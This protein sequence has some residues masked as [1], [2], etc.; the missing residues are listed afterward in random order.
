MA[1][2]K[3][4]REDCRAS[5]WQGAGRIAVRKPRIGLAPKS[6]SVLWRH[7]TARRTQSERRKFSRSCFFCSE[8]RSNFLITALASDA[9][10]PFPPRCS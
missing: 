2:A 7:P 4:L 6:L 1:D 10:R 8:S 3:Y 5:I 9:L